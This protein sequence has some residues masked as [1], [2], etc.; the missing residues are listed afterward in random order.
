R[1]AVGLGRT[2]GLG[3][4]LVA[5]V[6]RQAVT[7][8]ARRFIAGTT[9]EE[10]I[11]AAL[12]ARRAGQAFTIDLLGEACVSEEEADAYQR[13]YLELVRTLG[14]VART[15]RPD[16][17]IDQAPWGP[18]PRVNISVK[19]SA[20]YPYLDPV[21]PRDSARAVK[22]RL[23]PILEAARAHGAHIQIDAEDRRLKDL[24]LR[25]FM[26]LAEEDAW[27]TTRDLGVVQQAY[28]KEAESDARRLIDWARRRGTP[29]TVRL[30][31]GAYWDYE[32]AHARLLGWPV[33]A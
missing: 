27:R 18:L 28:L 12:R 3:Q 31:K 17:R 19:L 11:A 15:W 26:E 1:L 32:T 21:D 24:T 29:V 7:Q 20:L 5:G 14:E 25:I 9:A 6:L 2:G 8:L 23:R 4:K 33:P 16:P 30:V 10:A 13:R 22:G